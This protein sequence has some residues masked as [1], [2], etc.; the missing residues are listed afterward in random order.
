MAS[1]KKT[2][3]AA[4]VLHIALFVM[5][6]IDVDVSYRLAPIQK[7]I[8]PILVYAITFVALNEIGVAAFL[9]N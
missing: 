6:V 9:R 1:I 3:R 7:Q 2:L 5:V 4:R 8:P